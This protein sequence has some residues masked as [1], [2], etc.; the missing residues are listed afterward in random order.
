[1]YEWCGNFLNDNFIQKIMIMFSCNLYCNYA[2]LIR[3][4]SVWETVSLPVMMVAAGI[5]SAYRVLSNFRTLA[6]AGVI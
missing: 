6:S 2:N 3:I 5:G 4:Q 1:M